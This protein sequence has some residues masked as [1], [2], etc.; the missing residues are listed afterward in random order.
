MSPVILHK[1]FTVCSHVQ[2]N[3]ED[4]IK[5]YEKFGFEIVE[6]KDNYYKRIEPTDAYVLKKFFRKPDSPTSG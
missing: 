4:A 3:N 6:K 2:I 5:F 1:C